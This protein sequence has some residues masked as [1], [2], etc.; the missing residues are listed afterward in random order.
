M[1]LRNWVEDI[2][3]RELKKTLSRLKLSPK[4]EKALDAMT[5][6]IVNK[7]MHPVFTYLKEESAQGNA[8]KAKE[9]V[10]AVFALEEEDEN[11]DR[12]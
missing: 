3:T 7:I 9:V 10:K 12:H 1:A 2:R 5:N 8:R 11:K 6:A 4:E